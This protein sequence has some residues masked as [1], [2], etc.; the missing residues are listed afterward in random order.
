ME[1]EERNAPYDLTN[2][3]VSQQLKNYYALRKTFV[4]SS[5]DATMFLFFFVLMTVSIV[6]LS[7]FRT[8]ETIVLF[9]LCLICAIYSVTYA[10]LYRI[11]HHKAK[12]QLS[13]IPRATVERWKKELY[14]DLVYYTTIACNAQ[15]RRRVILPSFENFSVWRSVFK[16]YYVSETKNSEN[17]NV[18]IHVANHSLAHIKNRRRGKVDNTSCNMSSAWN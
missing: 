9:V 15:P 16:E 17:E 5:A 8:W 14:D 4:E 11:K 10:S 1:E 12:T 13:E 18:L 2:F 7:G 3:D 6:L